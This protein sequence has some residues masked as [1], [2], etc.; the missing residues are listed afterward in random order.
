MQ[1]HRCRLASNFCVVILLYKVNPAVALTITF[2]ILS[3]GGSATGGSPVA[4][5]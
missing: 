1:R 2:I 5:R 3:I 4:L